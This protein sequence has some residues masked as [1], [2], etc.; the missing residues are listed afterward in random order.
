MNTDVLNEIVNGLQAENKRLSKENHKLKDRIRKVESGCFDEFYT[1]AT[2]VIRL[3]PDEEREIAIN[4][5]READ[6]Y[7]TKLIRK[8]DGFQ[9]QIR[10]SSNDRQWSNIPLD[11]ELGA[12]PAHLPMILPKPRFIARAST[13]TVYLKN[14][15]ETMRDVAIAFAGF[16]VYHVEDLY[17]SA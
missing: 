14:T 2:P 9:F 17:T 1:Y 3:R 6:F 5:T 16:K 13:I 15:S 11:A 7:A 8:G 4:I 12:G 10:D